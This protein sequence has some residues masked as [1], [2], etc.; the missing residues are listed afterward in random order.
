MPPP[1]CLLAS[2]P[3]EGTLYIYIYIYSLRGLSFPSLL[4]P[5]HTCVTP[6]R[7]NHISKGG[8][9]TKAGTK[10]RWFIFLR[11][12]CSSSQNESILPARF[13]FVSKT[14]SGGRMMEP[15]L[16]SVCICIYFLVPFTPSSLPLCHLTSLSQVYKPRSEGRIFF[17]TCRTNPV[18]PK[19]MG[20]P[21]VCL[22]RRQDSLTATSKPTACSLRGGWCF[23][24]NLPRVPYLPARG[25]TVPCTRFG[26]GQGW[27]T[28]TTGR[29]V[30]FR[31]AVGSST[32]QAK[33]GDGFLEND[34]AARTDAIQPQTADERGWKDKMGTRTNS[35]NEKVQGGKQGLHGRRTFCFTALA[36]AT[37]L[38]SYAD[39]GNLASVIVP[40]AE[41]FGWSPSFEG[42]VLS[43]FFLGYAATQVRLWAPALT[44]WFASKS[45]VLFCTL[46]QDMR[47]RRFRCD[48]FSHRPPNGRV[49]QPL[50]KLQRT[51]PLIVRGENCRG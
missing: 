50:P 6:L 7:L 18:T 42:V 11:Y 9:P 35:G 2:Y 30:C 29:C 1:S 34:F 5:L 31:P 19:W 3:R 44:S 10:F 13:T 14:V 47:I 24:H 27:S 12:I 38:V 15:L 25:R 48:I 36:S 4:Y 45:V 37:I 43:A 8:P 23:G 22:R 17:S 28:V 21:V 20:S 51:V 40:M 32:T 26:R 16:C 46:E 41:Q 49:H 33:G 39:R